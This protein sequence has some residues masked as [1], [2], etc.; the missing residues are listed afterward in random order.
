[1]NIRKWQDRYSKATK[2]LNMPTYTE[3]ISK[4]R[5]DYPEKTESELEQ[6]ADIIMADNESEYQDKEQYGDE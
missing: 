1:M 2:V 3:T 6:I 4:L 5:Q